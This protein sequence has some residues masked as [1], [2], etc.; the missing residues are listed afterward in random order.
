MIDS[1]LAIKNSH[2]TCSRFLMTH[3]QATCVKIRIARNQCKFFVSG[4]SCHIYFNRYLFSQLRQLKR[5]E[6]Y[7]NKTARVCCNSDQERIRKDKP[8]DSDGSCLRVQMV[9]TIQVHSL[10]IFLM[11]TI[12]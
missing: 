9:H 5:P 1:F 7:K 11:T 8:S 10:C 6:H 3:F 2:N 4:R 12:S